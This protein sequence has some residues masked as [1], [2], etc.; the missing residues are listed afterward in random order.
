VSY[1]VKIKKVWEVS[2]CLVV[3]VTRRD[4]EALDVGQGD[5]LIVALVR[6]PQGLSELEVAAAVDRG[7][8]EALLGVKGE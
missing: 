3:T 6:V 5:E 8:R 1:V 2:G 4:I 7:V